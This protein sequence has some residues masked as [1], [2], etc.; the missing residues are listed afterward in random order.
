MTQWQTEVG[1]VMATGQAVVSL[2]RPE[3]REAVVDLPVG[4]LASLDDSRQIRVISQLDERVW[5]IA[6]VR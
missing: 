2:A 1:Q 3:S 6:S 4:L 5:V